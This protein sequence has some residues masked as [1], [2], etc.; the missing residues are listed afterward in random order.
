MSD[1]WS[2][3]AM[4]TLKHAGVMKRNMQKKEIKA[5]KAKCP[6]CDGYWHARLAGPKQRLHMGCDGDCGAMMME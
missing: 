2:A 5:G 4:Q 6:Y 1:D 3:R